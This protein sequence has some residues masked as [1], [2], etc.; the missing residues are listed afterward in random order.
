MSGQHNV[1]KNGKLTA[2][3]S[4]DS[5]VFGGHPAYVK[6]MDEAAA[7][8]RAIVKQ[9]KKVFTP[10]F[11]PNSVSDES[12]EREIAQEEERLFKPKEES[13]EDLKGMIKELL[14]EVLTEMRESGTE[15]SSP[16]STKR[17][18]REAK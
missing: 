6:E 8:P 9:S 18:M 16:V 1:V 17:K 13:R 5:L 4:G 12:V 11:D 3:D 7:Q 14:T 15:S 10:G 2:Y